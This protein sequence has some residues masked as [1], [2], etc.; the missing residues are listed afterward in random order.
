MLSSCLNP[1]RSYVLFLMGVGVILDL[2]AREIT[3]IAASK[4]IIIV[5]E[6]VL[7]CS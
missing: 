5:V 7:N 6:M 2:T 1:H 4:I 3:E